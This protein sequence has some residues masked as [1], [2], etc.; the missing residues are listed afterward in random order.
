ML[1]AASLAGL[2]MF[3]WPLLLRVPAGRRGVDPPFL[4]LAL[5]PLVIVV[6]L[7][8]FSEGGMDAKV[9]AML[10]VPERGQRRAAR[11]AAPAPPASSWC[12]SC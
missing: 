5:L 11:A 4:F 3:S 10:G 1:G 7:A 8:E 2:M 12:S 6:V 9:L